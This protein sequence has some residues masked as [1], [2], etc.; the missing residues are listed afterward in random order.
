MPDP[1]IIKWINSMKNL[2]VKLE[3]EYINQFKSNWVT[4]N[5]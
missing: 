3:Y 1:S 2:L 4:I 5:D